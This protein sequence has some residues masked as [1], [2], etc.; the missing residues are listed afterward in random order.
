MGIGPSGDTEGGGSVDDDVGC[1]SGLD[2]RGVVPA[3]ALEPSLE[4][5]FGG[6]QVTFLAIA[7]DVGENEVVGEVARIARPGHEVV[8]MA[9]A[10]SAQAI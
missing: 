8:D 4:M 7:F 2:D 5:R 1:A 10:D 9:G 6:E 3:I